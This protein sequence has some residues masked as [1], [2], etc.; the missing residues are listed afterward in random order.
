MRLTL[1]V[2]HLPPG[3]IGGAELQAQEWAQRLARYHEVSVVT[4]QDS[5][6]QSRLERRDGIQ[7]VRTPVAPVPGWRAAANLYATDA[8]IRGMPARP[9]L[10]LCFQTFLSGLAGVRAQRRLGAPAIVWVRGEWEYRLRESLRARFF[11]R[12]VWDGARGILVQS[13]ANRSAMLT[14]LD[15]VDPSLARRVEAKLRVVPNGITIPKS[16]PPRGSKVVMLGRLIPDKGVDV[17]IKAL[18]GLPKIELLV[19]GDGPERARLEALASSH[20][21]AARFLGFVPRHRLGDIFAQARCL[22]LAS[23][24][25]EGFPNAI[26]EA[27]A[28]GVPVV[29][30]PIAGVRD[31][32]DDGRN[33]LLIPPGDV[34]GLRLALERMLV[35]DHL[36]GQ[37]STIGRGTAAAYSWERVA[38][39]LEEVL[40]LWSSIP[41]DHS[42]GPGT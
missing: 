26:L 37:F 24:S 20:R 32:V 39:R 10:L 23:R 18:V 12:R 41:V 15:A 22:V 17:V 38:P 40:Q 11:S 33:G 34:G 2:G 3:R 14:E 42:I 7:I 8:A 16:T 35:D 4:R 30:T 13:E 31:L 25:G 9:D 21:V 27:M 1:L 6:D 5:P 28:W 29:A 36:C 19:V